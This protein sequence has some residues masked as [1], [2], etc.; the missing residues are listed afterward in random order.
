MQDV[1]ALRQQVLV[2]GRSQRR[3]ARELV[4]SGNTV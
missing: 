3:A 2:E 4:I 1:L